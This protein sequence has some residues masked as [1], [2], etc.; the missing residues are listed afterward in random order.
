MPGALHRL[1]W[2]Q[3]FKGRMI[4]G[5]EDVTSAG[6][7]LRRASA[8]QGGRATL[9]RQAVNPV[10]CACTCGAT[11]FQT[12]GAPRFRVLCHCTL[13]QRFHDAPFAD[14]LVHRAEDV[15][16]P[17]PELVDFETYKPP[18]NVRRGRCATC[19]QPA[20]AV[21]EAPVLPRLVMVPSPMFEPGAILPPPAAHIF[22]DKRLA[23]AQ[24]PYPKYEGYVRS[25]YAFLKYLW[26]A[27]RA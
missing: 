8:S 19:G 15:I 21:F 27:R 25:Q 16:A 22:Y 4:T 7:T 13:C 9:N 20:V 1:S 11:S 26:S 6:A 5:Q 3:V 12:T 10:E 2:L 24:D 18:P 17:S 14:V 23:D